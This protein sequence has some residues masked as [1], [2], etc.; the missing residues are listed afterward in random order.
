M[1][2]QSFE[3]MFSL[4]RVIDVSSHSHRRRSKKAARPKQRQEAVT[5]R[6]AV[7]GKLQAMVSW[8][9]VV[10][11]VLSSS[12]SSHT[13]TTIQQHV[14]WCGSLDPHTHNGDETMFTAN[15]AGTAGNSR[16]SAS[17]PYAKSHMPDPLVQSVQRSGSK[18]EVWPFQFANTLTD[19][20]QKAKKHIA[21]N[22]I[23][24]NFNLN[25]LILS[26]VLIWL[27]LWQHDNH[28]WNH[29]WC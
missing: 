1:Q 4:R 11:R 6:A 3:T 26:P 13:L 12:P 2:Q 14:M 29:R 27:M 21:H 17:L 10:N 23:S 16:R 5:R 22:E 20:K 9:I 28:S 7:V 8:L 18:P 19:L 24:L 25:W 15:L